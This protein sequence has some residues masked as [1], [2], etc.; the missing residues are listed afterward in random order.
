M[1]KSREPIHDK[2][3]VKY[4]ARL[5]GRLHGFKILESV[6]EFNCLIINLTNIDNEIEDEDKAIIDPQYALSNSYS[7][8]VEAMK[9]ARDPLSLD[10]IQTG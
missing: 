2:N 6:D 8:F 4:R 7:T 1:A 3:V 9:Y 5:N 10:N